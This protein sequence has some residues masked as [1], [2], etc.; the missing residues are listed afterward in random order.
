MPDDAL[1]S[2]GQGAVLSILTINDL[3]AYIDGELDAELVPDV[4][5]MLDEDPRV[6]RWAAAYRHQIACM[7]RAFAKGAD[8]VPQRLRAPVR[9]AVGRE[10]D[11]E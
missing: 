8:D 7:H 11:I 4:E 10:P 6:A 9:A 3:H 5:G 2:D 1:N